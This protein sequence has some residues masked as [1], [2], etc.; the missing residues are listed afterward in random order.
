LEAE[1]QAQEDTV[2]GDSERLKGVFLNLLLNGADAM[3]NGGRLQISTEAVNAKVRV[4][5]ADEGPGI[6]TEL[7]DKIFEPFYSTKKEGTGFGLAMALQ[8]VEEHEGTIRIA[9]DTTVKGAVFVVE[10]P[11]VPREKST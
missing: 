5:I 8:A 4:R 1:L 6:P 7:E 9:E 2:R 3:P 10:L 11:L